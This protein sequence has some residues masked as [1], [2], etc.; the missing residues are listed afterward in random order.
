MIDALVQDDNV[1]LPKTGTDKPTA[2]VSVE[3]ML[4]PVSENISQELPLRTLAPSQSLQENNVIGKTMSG[5]KSAV[6][7]SPPVRVSTTAMKFIFKNE[8]VVENSQNTDKIKRHD[9]SV[10]STDGV[11]QSQKVKETV[12]APSSDLTPE[13]SLSIGTNLKLLIGD[14]GKYSFSPDIPKDLFSQ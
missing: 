5:R 12:N 2:A 10:I 1:S 4:S 8:K 14:N 11:H 7:R 3:S 6:Y 9:E 13:K